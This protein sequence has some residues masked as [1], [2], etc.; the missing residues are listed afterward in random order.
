MKNKSKNK[1]ILIIGQAPPLKAQKVPYDSTMLYEWLQ[2]IGVNKKYAQKL[3]DF[4]ALTDEIPDVDGKGNHRRPRKQ[5]IVDYLN[6]V[7]YKK[8]VNSEVIILLGDCSIKYFGY[9]GFFIEDKMQNATVLTCI[10]PSTRNRY[11]FNKNKEEVLNVF[12]RAIQLNKGN[13]MYL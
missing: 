1:K 3:F 12:N 2:E 6:R 11:R 7:L 4:E 5:Q 8:I 9:S 10:H 13:N